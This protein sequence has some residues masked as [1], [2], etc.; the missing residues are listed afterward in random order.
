MLTLGA[1]PVHAR[2]LHSHSRTIAAWQHYGKITLGIHLSG[3]TIVTKRPSKNLLTSKNKFLTRALIIRLGFRKKLKILSSTM[4]GLSPSAITFTCILKA[5]RK[6]GALYKGIEIHAQI[7]RQG[8][9]CDDVVLGTF[10]VPMYAKC[11]A[12]AKAQIVL[13]ELPVRIAIS[14]NA[15]ISAYVQQNNA[16]KALDCY[17]RMRSEGLSPDAVTFSCTLKAC[18]CVGASA[19]GEE[20]HFEID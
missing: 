17:E 1:L 16:K 11:N 18:G 6:L 15:L 8:L 19:I 13:N 5:C 20:I 4:K 3:G 2:R 9:L 7:A 12:L 14:W 10:L